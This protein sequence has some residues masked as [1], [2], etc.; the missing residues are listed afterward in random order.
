MN[1]RFWKIAHAYEDA[2]LLK[3]SL[4]YLKMAKN[5]MPDFA[6][7]IDFD[8]NRVNVFECEDVDLKFN[9]SL[10]EENIL[11]QV[12]KIKKSGLF[13]EKWFLN[14]YQDIDLKGFSALE[15]FVRFGNSLNLNPNEDFSTEIYIGLYGGRWVEEISAFYRYLVRGR[16]FEE[17]SNAIHI[18]DQ[19]KRKNNEIKFSDVLLDQILPL[20]LK[21]TSSIIKANDAIKKGMESDWLNL[22][23]TYLANFVS[24]KLELISE[25]EN[26]FDR[27]RVSKKYVLNKITNGDLITVIMPAWNAEKTIKKSVNSILDQTW[28]NIE[29]IIVDDASTDKTYEICL[30]LAKND[31]RV[32]V[33]K[34]SKNV[35]PYVSKNYALQ[36]A[37][38]DW[39]TGHDADDYA[40]PDRLEQHIEEAV[41]YG[42]DASITYMIR[43]RSDGFFDHLGKV[44]STSF[45]GV[46]RK[47]S[48]TCLF[49]RSVLENNLGFWDSVRY[50]ADSEL[51]DRAEI[52]LKERFGVIKKVSMICLNH[53]ESL[54]NNRITG[55]R[56][57]VGMSPIRVK[58]REAWMDWHAKIK[59]GSSAYLS[60]GACDRKYSVPDEMNVSLEL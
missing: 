39:I 47:A 34:N 18:L 13:D 43:M 45:D 15:F 54:T 35:G 6:G 24:Y 55:I 60:F 41:R 16:V 56:T 48:I 3:H 2:N 25:G 27:L 20:K 51:I 10:F 21:Y 30:E 19:I 8:I 31:D 42:Y 23:N 33:I 59:T 38:G 44:G 17:N 53:E 28:R 12:N 29:L 57:G 14:N 22:T 49:K 5:N 52:I 26:V 58:Y 32:K 46:A 9:F 37:R 7:L 50:G 1:T 4:I 40:L 11:K 36:I